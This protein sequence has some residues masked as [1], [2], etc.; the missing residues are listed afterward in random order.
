[1]FIANQ[2]YRGLEITQAAETQATKNAANGGPAAT[3]QA[4]NVQTG[5]ALAAQLFHLLDLVERSTA[6]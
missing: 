1:M 6:R 5:E 3:S 2:G 4:G